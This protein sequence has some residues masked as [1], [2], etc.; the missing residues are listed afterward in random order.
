MKFFSGI[1]RNFP[2]VLTLALES[3]TKLGRYESWILAT[4]NT[5]DAI[6]D[7]EP[8]PGIL[9]QFYS[10]D[11]AGEREFMRRV[12]GYTTQLIIGDRKPLTNQAMAV[13]SISPDQIF[14]QPQA[15]IN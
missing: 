2:T 13:I 15:H 1:T 3:G 10:A 11:N 6:L 7:L 14:A 9:N 5:D 4:W 8:Q 12:L